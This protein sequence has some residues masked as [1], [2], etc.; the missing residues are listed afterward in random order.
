MFRK[1]TKYQINDKRKEIQKQIE[2]IDSELSVLR[3]QLREEVEKAM[4]NLNSKYMAFIAPLLAERSRLL[5][6]MNRV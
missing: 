6:D 1:K 3:E 5:E 4:S 2:G